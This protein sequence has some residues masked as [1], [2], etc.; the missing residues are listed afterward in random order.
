MSKVP[1]Q[2]IRSFAAI[3]EK[4]KRNRR[5]LYYVFGL[6]VVMATSFAF[7][8]SW[9]NPTLF[10]G[11]LHSQTYAIAEQFICAC[12]TCEKI[13][14][15]CGCAMKGGGLEEMRF[16]SDLLENGIDKTQIIQRVR[17]HYGHYID[18]S[19]SK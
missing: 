8:L 17:V 14:A 11:P 12:G 13:L 7:W 6:I 9:S 10:K 3:R 19:T 18:Q 1:V 4:Q 5:R 16:I 2:K 15:V